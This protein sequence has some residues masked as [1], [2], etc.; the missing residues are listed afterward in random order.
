MPL[1]N[2]LIP[3]DNSPYC[4]FNSRMYYEILMLIRFRFNLWVKVTKMM[5]WTN[6]WSSC[7]QRSLINLQWPNFMLQ[8]TWSFPWLLSSSFVFFFIAHKYKHSAYFL[9]I[10]NRF[11]ETPLT[12]W[13]SIYQLIFEL[14]WNI[15]WISYCLLI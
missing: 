11:F 8:I 1:G 5:K 4:I 2:L 14:N 7:T 12:F 13:I 15:N 10:N 6:V 3:S 9:K